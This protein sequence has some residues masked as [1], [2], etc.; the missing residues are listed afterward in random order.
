MEIF[1]ARDA[2]D[3]RDTFRQWAS[4]ALEWLAA[5]RETKAKRS[6]P[7]GNAA[8]GLLEDARAIAAKL[9]LQ[10]ALVALSKG[11]EP[12]RS[13][14]FDGPIDDM[15]RELVA[16]KFR[17]LLK[18]LPIAARRGRGPRENTVAIYSDILENNL[19]I[20]D[21]QVRY[22]VSK[23]NARQLKC[24]AAKWVAQQKRDT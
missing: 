4:C 23:D 5:D 12:S 7:C 1:R 15:S 8:N 22:P 20:A 18:A 21:I 24:R 9:R 19:S 2:V 10:K 17:L 13:S 14:D 6:G 11:P 16:E 3:D